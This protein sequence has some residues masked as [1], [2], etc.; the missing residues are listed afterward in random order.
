MD[1]GKTFGHGVHDIQG[2]VVSHLWV[3]LQRV[4]CTF[5]FNATFFQAHLLPFILLDVSR[6]KPRWG[7]YFSMKNCAHLDSTLVTSCFPK[8]KT[9]VDLLPKH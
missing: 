9:C 8:L 2:V 6:L 1:G 4:C 5:V 3:P 7:F